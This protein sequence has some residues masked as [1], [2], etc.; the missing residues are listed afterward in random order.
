MDKPVSTDIKGPAA[1]LRYQVKTLLKGMDDR[2]EEAGHM[3]QQA[4]EA[5][6]ADDE[7]ATRRYSD[8]AVSLQEDLQGVSDRLNYILGDIDGAGE[9]YYYAP[10]NRFRVASSRED[11]YLEFT[12]GMS[13]EVWSTERLYYLDDG[14]WKPDRVEYS[15]KEGQEGYCLYNTGKLLEPGMRVRHRRTDD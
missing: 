7:F 5:G 6:D 10:T 9:L 1:Q 11:N 12:C 3:H 14:E 8:I 4:M 13:I 15:H 2:I